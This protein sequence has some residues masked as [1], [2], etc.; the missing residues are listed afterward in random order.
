[1]Y[2]LPA[3]K[4]PRW[5]SACSK[6]FSGSINLVSR[7]CEGCELIIPTFGFLS[8]KKRR[9]CSG[10]AKSHVGAVNLNAAA[11]AQLAGREEGADELE[12]AA[13]G[14]GGDDGGSAPANG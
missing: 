14:A 10:C 5:C 12:A 8:E 11:A 1:M 6:E 13:A 9:W 2:G 3:E 4:R 7:M